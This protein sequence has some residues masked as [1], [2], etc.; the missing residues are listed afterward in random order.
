M[1]DVVPEVRQILR[2]PEC[3]Y[4]LLHTDIA[5]ELFEIGVD[6]LLHEPADQPRN[7]QAVQMSEFI[8][9]KSPPFGAL[10][11]LQA[12]HTVRKIGCN[13]KIVHLKLPR[14]YQAHSSFQVG[15]IGRE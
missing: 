10:K 9:T 5:A 2:K 3:G 4:T 12:G 14:R 1:S 15:Q 8:F 6:Q 7:S 11:D 13:A